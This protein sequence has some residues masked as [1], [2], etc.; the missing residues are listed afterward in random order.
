MAILSLSLRGL[1]SF[2]GHHFR[3]PQL[4]CSHYRKCLQL[5]TMCLHTKPQ[6]AT[7]LRDIRRAQPFGLSVQLS[8]PFFLGIHIPPLMQSQALRKTH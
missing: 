8:S 5:V 3:S 1:E 7:L 2:L 6:L 4:F